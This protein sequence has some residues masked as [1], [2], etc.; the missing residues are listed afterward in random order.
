MNRPPNNPINAP[1]KGNKPD[2]LVRQIFLKDIFLKLKTIFKYIF[3]QHYS[4]YKS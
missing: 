3:F 2:M 1:I 4:K